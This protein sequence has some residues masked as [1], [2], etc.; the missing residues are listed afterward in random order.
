MSLDVTVT[1]EEV[2]S[3]LLS[4]IASLCEELAVKDARM[5]VLER[6]IMGMQQGATIETGP[7]EYGHEGPTHSTGGIV[8][9]APEDKEHSHG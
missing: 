9:P 2:I 8:P 4:R 3:H 7:S 6:A 5:Q 1:H